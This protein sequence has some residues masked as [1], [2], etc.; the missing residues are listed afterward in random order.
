MTLPYERT[1]SVLRTIGFL[2]RLCSPYDGGIK[3]VRKEIRQEAR[4]L[5]R[6][7]PGV[8]DLRQASEKCPEVFG[9]S[10]PW[11][12]YGDLDE[13]VDEAEGFDDECTTRTNPQ[14]ECGSDECD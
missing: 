4:S 11:G 1:S 12:R 14:G 7:F 9:F 2:T 6:H 5:L 10:N 13:R 3:G 8:S